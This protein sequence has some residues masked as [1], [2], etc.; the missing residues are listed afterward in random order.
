MRRI[1][2][3]ILFSFAL[4]A[5]CS[6]WSDRHFQADLL[7]SSGLSLLESDVHLVFEANH[8]ANFGSVS[9]VVYG[10]KISH[11]D[12]LLE[13]CGNNG[14]SVAGMIDPRTVLSTPEIPPGESQG[15]YRR[16]LTDAGATRII[17]LLQHTVY[18]MNMS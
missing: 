3:I 18:I 12:S 10:F 4:L 6:K 15:C 1:E 7:E 13:E 17:L 5:G 9:V 14:Y 2:T 11:R 8:S 16:I